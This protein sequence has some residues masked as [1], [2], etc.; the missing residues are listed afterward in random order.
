MKFILTRQELNAWMA[1]LDDAQAGPG[2]SRRS[3]RPKGERKLSI[4][5]ESL[6]AGLP[7]EA[8]TSPSLPRP[9]A[10]S[11]C[12]RAPDTPAH[13]GH[14]S[15]SRRFLFAATASCKLGKPVFRE[16]QG[17]PC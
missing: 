12:R 14:I 2:L 4:G 17:K 6:S 13:T 1:R 16:D 15:S 3:D 11:V 8:L 10:G 5:N 9:P 7:A